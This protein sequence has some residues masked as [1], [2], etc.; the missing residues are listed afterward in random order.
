MAS[1]IITKKVL[2][3]NRKYRDDSCKS[4]GTRWNDAYKSKETRW[5]DACKSKDN[6]QVS[7]AQKCQVSLLQQ[8]V[9]ITV[10]RETFA[11]KIF[12]SLAVATKIRHAM[13]YQLHG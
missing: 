2:T 7:H 11:V 5:D 1:V 8:L 3:K 10:D 13:L 12:L 9:I 6:T 4:K